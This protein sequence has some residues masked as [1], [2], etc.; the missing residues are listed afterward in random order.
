[1]LSHGA[2]SGVETSDGVW[3][4]FDAVVDLSPLEVKG[5]LES[6]QENSANQC[7]VCSKKFLEFLF[8]FPEEKQCTKLTQEIKYR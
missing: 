4:G 3:F 8:F 7:Q 2:C 6:V 5:S 1:M